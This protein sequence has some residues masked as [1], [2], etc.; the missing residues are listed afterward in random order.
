MKACDIWFLEEQDDT[1]EMQEVLDFIFSSDAQGVKLIAMRISEARIHEE[2]EALRS[3]LIRKVMERK[4]F[5]KFLSDGNNRAHLDML[6]CNIH[7]FGVGYLKVDSDLSVESIDPR[8]VKR[9]DLR[10]TQDE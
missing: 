4:F 10:G 6:M 3:F 7:H 9:I 5:K 1:P 2:C 8:D